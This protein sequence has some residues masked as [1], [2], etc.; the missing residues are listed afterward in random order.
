[1]K[2]KNINWE[3]V[4][5]ADQKQTAVIVNY[6]N[7]KSTFTRLLLGRFADRQTAWN[8]VLQN[9]LKPGV[10]YGEEQ[11]A[12]QIGVRLL[13]LSKVVREYT[14]TKPKNVAAYIVA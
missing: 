13:K 9:D 11:Q 7:G 8:W 14:E 10:R 5:A 6:N 2:G 1:M 3:Q 4:Q 12:V